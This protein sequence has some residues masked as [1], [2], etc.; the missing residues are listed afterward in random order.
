MSENGRRDNSDNRCTLVVNLTSSVYRSKTMDKY[1]IYQN[2]TS[3]MS[4]AEQFCQLAGRDC[5]DKDR[6]H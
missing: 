1:P 2:G 6:P 3:G 5:A 4:L